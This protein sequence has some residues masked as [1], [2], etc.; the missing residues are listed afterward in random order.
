MAAL[1]AGYD[2]TNGPELYILETAGVSYRYTAVAIGKGRQAA[3]TELEKLKFDTMTV[4]QAVKEV[5]RIIHN[6]HDSVKDKDF[7]LDMYVLYVYI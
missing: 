4:R 5:A 1:V 2:A 6:V 7:E 3:K